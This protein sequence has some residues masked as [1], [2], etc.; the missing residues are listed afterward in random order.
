[1]E[2]GWEA[3]YAGHYR[4]LVGLLTALAGS[5]AEAEEAVQEAFVRALGV[6]GRRRV[7]DEPEAYLYR[8]ATNIIRSR[9]R[10][11][12]RGRQMVAQRA[13]RDDPDDDHLRAESR[14][15]LLAALRRLP[16]AQREALVLHYLADLPLAAVALRVGAPLGTVKARLSRGR[17]AL[18]RMLADEPIDEWRE[19]PRN[20]RS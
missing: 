12:L 14:L 4:R 9:W 11:A 7:L 6:T 19:E 15:V 18:Q 20:A 2:D 1:M 13:E 3:V 5:R 8:V 17:D 10:R 16:F